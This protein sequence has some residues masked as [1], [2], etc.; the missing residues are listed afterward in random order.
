[1]SALDDGPCGQVSRLLRERGIAG[2]RARAMVDQVI[3]TWLPPA[4]LLDVRRHAAELGIPP[5]SRAVERAFLL[6]QGLA[7]LDQVPSLPS[8]ESSAATI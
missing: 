3:R 4:D 2:I 8:V 1:M 7:A 6:E 5:E